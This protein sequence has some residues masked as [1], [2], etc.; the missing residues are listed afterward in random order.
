[1]KVIE[2]G[3]FYNDFLA[4]CQSSDFLQA[5]LQ[6]ITEHSTYSSMASQKFAPGTEYA[7]R[8]RSGPDLVNYGGEW[9]A[10]SSEVHWRTEEGESA[11]H[12]GAQLT[13]QLTSKRACLY[14]PDTST[15]PRLTS[16]YGLAKVFVP[17]CVLV[18]FVLLCSVY[19]KM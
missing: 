6:T 9:S 15:R 3:A 17:V 7:A 8:V 12:G 13:V 14:L 11:H 18:P 5:T 19:F 1:M 2:Q 16:M 10:W 4:P